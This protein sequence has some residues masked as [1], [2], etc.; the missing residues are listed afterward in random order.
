MELPVLIEEEAGRGVA[1]ELGLHISGIAGQLLKTV[2]QDAI[3][4]DDASVRKLQ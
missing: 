3:S 4:V 1:R 2:R